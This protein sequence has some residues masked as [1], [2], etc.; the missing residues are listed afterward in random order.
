MQVTNPLVEPLARDETTGEYVARYDWK[1]P[2]PVSTILV[3]L[4][5]DVTG[6]DPER[7]E[8]LGRVADPEAIDSLFASTGLYS[9][10]Y[11]AASRLAFRFEDTHVTLEADGVIRLDP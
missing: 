10:N 7:L 9:G 1:S 3:E 5:A 2:V 4:V 6:S 8:P 11:D